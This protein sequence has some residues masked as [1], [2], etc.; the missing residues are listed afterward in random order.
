MKKVLGKKGLCCF[1]AFV[2]CFQMFF[3]NG[4]TSTIA[5]AAQST[6]V[7]QQKQQ[8]V[9]ASSEV[10]S[11]VASQDGRSEDSDG[12]SAASDADSLASSEKRDSSTGVDS[13]ASESADDQEAEEIEPEASGDGSAASE[14]AVDK[15]T[16]KKQPESADVDSDAASKGESDETSKG[17][18]DDTS[19]DETADA[20]EK[21]DGEDDVTV[22][23][24][25]W[26][27]CVDNLTLSTDGLE[28]AESLAAQ[29]GQ[30][31]EQSANGETDAAVVGESAADVK[32]VALPDTLNAQLNIKA[33]LDV[34]AGEGRDGDV[35]SEIVGGDNF[36]IALPDGITANIKSAN[37][38]TT[39]GELRADVYSLD[40]ATGKASKEV[41]G[42]AVVN[43]SSNTI[44]IK[45]NAPARKVSAIQAVIDLDVLV[46]SDLVK[47]KESTV[48]WTIQKGG[49]DVKL[50]VPSKLDVATALGLIDAENAIQI[51]EETSA[52][53]NN[54]DESTG[55]QIGDRKK[56]QSGKTSA[57]QFVTHWADNNAEV[58]P[59]AST[60]QSGNEYRLYY[61]LDGGTTKKALTIDGVNLTDEAKADL[62]IES[63][64]PSTGSLLS[65]SKTA[66][67]DYTVSSTN[68][69]PL[70]I[71]TK[72]L[73]RIDVD[74]ETGKE[75]EVWEDIDSKTV[76]YY[77]KHD[78]DSSTGAAIA[79]SS[80]VYPGTDGK[81]QYIVS[82][83]SSLKT[84]DQ[85]AGKYINE[86]Q[87]EVL[88]LLATQTFTVHYSFGSGVDDTFDFMSFFM[89]K[90][91][92]QT[93]TVHIG[94]FYYNLNGEY[95]TR[96]YNEGY[97]TGSWSDSAPHSTGTIVVTAPEYYPDGTLME[98]SYTQQAEDQDP[99]PDYVDEF[100]IRYDNSAGTNHGSD[101]SAVYDGGTVYLVH[102]GTTK[103]AATKKWADD[104]ASARPETTYSLWRYVDNGSGD[105]GTA[106]PVKAADNSAFIEFTIS[107]AV[108]QAA[109]SDGI[110]LG[111]KLKEQ[112]SATGTTLAKYDP[113]G[114]SY[115]YMLREDAVN[116]YERLYGTTINTDESSAD[117]GKIVKGSDTKPN[118]YGPDTTQGT[119][120]A[121]VAKDTRP[122][123]DR[124]VYNNGTIINRRT[125]TAT[126][127]AEKSWVVGTFQ[128]LLTNV[129]SVFQLQRIAKVHA[130]QN[131]DGTYSP[132]GDIDE[133]TGAAYDWV[134][135]AGGTKE[136]TGW[137]AETLTQEF[138]GGGA[139]YDALGEE[140][141]YR[142][143]ETD[144][145]QGDTSVVTSTGEDGVTAFHLTL[146]DN[147]GS[148]QDVSFNVTSTRDT[149]T[150]E[151]KIKNTYVDVTDA[152]V[153]KY[154][155]ETETDDEGNVTVKKD[156][157]GNIIWTQD[158]KPNGSSHSIKF[159]IVRTGVDGN[160]TYGPYTL[161]GTVD[162]EATK[163]DG[164]DGATVQETTPW[165]FD[166]ENLPM[167]DDNGS[168]YIYMCFETSGA[169][170]WSSS[171]SYTPKQGSE[172]NVTTVYNSPSPGD[173]WSRLS[174]TKTWVDGGNTSSRVPVKVGIYA[175][176]EMYN[177]KYKDWVD[178]G[179]QGDMPSGAVHYNEGD[180]IRTVTL[181]ESNGWYYEGGISI[182]NVS[183]KN[184]DVYIRELSNGL[185]G[186]QQSTIITKT[187]AQEKYDSDPTTYAVYSDL[188]RNWGENANNKYNERMLT[189]AS[190]E[191]EAYCYQVSY[192]FSD[193]LN[194][195][196]VENRR[197]GQT[198]IRVTK[199]WSDQGHDT[200][201]RPT[202]QFKI[203]CTTSA[204]TF[205]AGDDG[206][207]YAQ[208]NGGNKVLL[209][210]EYIA[211]AA[212]VPMTTADATVSEDGR[213]L[214]FSIDTTDEHDT[215]LV[216]SLPK[217][218]GQGFVFGYNVEEEITQ[219]G[220]E[221]Y[222]KQTNLTVKYN[223]TYHFTDS[224]QVEFTNGRTGTKDVVFNT[225]WYDAY[226]SSTLDSR[227]DL[228][229]T[230]YKSVYQYDESGNLV[231]NDDGTP[232][233]TYE[234]VSDYE[235]YKWS[236]LVDST[237]GHDNERATIK[238][239]Q[240]YDSHGK[241]IIYYATCATHTSQTALDNLDYQKQWD[242]TTNQGVSGKDAG[243]DVW[244]THNASDSEVAIAAS[245]ATLSDTATALREDGTF[246]YEIA[247]SI[248][249]SG[250]KV[251]GNFPGE[252]VRADL[253]KISVYVQRRVAN[254]DTAWQN[255][256]FTAADNAQGYTID[257]M[258]SATGTDVA[259]GKTVLA[260]THDLTYI[261]AGKFSFAMK[262][263]GTN[264][265]GSDGTI[266]GET[267][268][269]ELP[270]YDANGNLYEYRTIEVVD[271][272]LSTDSNPVPGGFTLDELNNSTTDIAKGNPDK[273]FVTSSGDGSSYTIN[274]NYGA[275]TGKLTVKK[276]FDG[277]TTGDKFSDLT[278]TLYRYYI[279]SSDGTHS[280]TEKV[281]TKTLEAG[282][283]GEDGTGT[284][285]F[286][287]VEI[288][289]P[290][291]Q[292]WVYYVEETS[293]DGYT[294]QVMLGNASG[295]GDS[296]FADATKTD[297]GYASPD[298]FEK[299]D[300]GAYSKSTRVADD[301]T[302]DFTFK[303]TYV[304]ESIGLT[305]TKVW[306]DNGNVA[307]IRPS[308]ISITVK[309]TYSDGTADQSLTDGKLVLQ[310]TDASAA[311]YLQWTKSD[312]G[313]WTY[314]VSNV[315]KWAT[316]GA[317]WRYTVT[318][319]SSSV[320][321]TEY[322]IASTGGTL[323]ASDGASF[324]NIVNDLKT[325]IQPKKVWAGDDSDWLAQRPTLYYEL[326]ARFTSGDTT[327]AWEEVGNAFSNNT[328]SCPWAENTI[329]VSGTETLT[330][331]ML[332][333]QSDTLSSVGSVAP[334]GKG[335][336]ERTG[337]AWD[338]L[339]TSA[340]VG[341]VVKS[342]EYRVV[343]KYLVY[344]QDSGAPTVV[345]LADPDA[346][347][348]YAETYYPYS[349]SISSSTATGD[350]GQVTITST[351]TNTLDST[352]VSVTKNWDDEDN[353]WASRPGTTTATDEWTLQFAIQRSTDGANWEWV[354]TRG[355]SVTDST[356]L[357]TDGTFNEN[358]RVVELSSADAT[359]SK[360]FESLPA[361]D[362][363]GNS[364]TYRLAE[365][366]TG[367]YAVSTASTTIATA[368]DG[369][370]KLVAVDG[371][372]SVTFNNS[373]STVG[374]EGTKNWNDYSADLVPDFDTKK[375]TLQLQQSTDGT[376][377]TAAKY[378]DGTVPT[379]TWT[380]ISDN[381]WTY[382]YTGLPATD[383]DGN[384]ITYRARE[385]MDAS[386]GYV[387]SSYTE[388]T[389]DN[390]RQAFVGEAITNTATRFSLK[391]IGD[392]T[393]GSDSEELDGVTLKI[394]KTTDGVTK[395]YAVW[396]HDDGAAKSYVNVDGVASDADDDMSN[397]KE[398]TG[399]NAGYI[400]ALAAGT[401]TIT[402]T[403]TPDGHLQAADATVTIG[404]DGVISVSGA[405]LE[406][407]N[408]TAD[409]TDSV[410]RG[411]VEMYKYYM[412]AGVQVQM[413][414]MTFDLYQGTPDGTNVKIAEGI[415]LQNYAKDNNGKWYG[416][417]TGSLGDKLGAAVN[418]LTDAS[419]TSLLGKYYTTTADGLPLGNYFFKET[420]TSPYTVKAET[421][422]AFEITAN[423]DATK[424]PDNIFY[425][426]ANTEFN[427]EAYVAKAN[428]EDGST[429]NNATFKL[430]YIPEGSTS[431]EWTTIGSDFVTGATY[432]IGA[433]MSGSTKVD[434]TAGELR[435]KY[436]KKGQYRLT[437]LSDAGYEV[438]A[439]DS[440]TVATWTISEDDLNKTVDLA[441]GSNLAVPGV[442]WKNAAF[443]DGKL[444]N[445]PKH[446]AVKMTKVSSA[447][448]ATTIS[449][450]TMKLQKK[451]GDTWVD[452]VADSATGSTDLV[453]GKNYLATVDATGA[454]TA[455]T[456]DASTTADSGTISV[457]NLPWG[458]YKFV[459]TKQADGYVGKTGS[460]QAWVESGELA[461]S[462][463]NVETSQTSPVSG[464]NVVNNP[465]N[466][467]IIKANADGTKYL[468]GAKFTV[469]GKFVSGG[470]TKIMTKN[471]TS[472]VNTGEAKP[473]SS[474]DELEGQL[475]VGETYTVTESS[476]PDGY[477]YDSSTSTYRVT[478]TDTGQVVAA[479]GQ[480]AVSGWSLSSGDAS[481]TV[482]TLTR[483]NTPTKIIVFKTDE[484]GD[485]LSGS[486]FTITGE[487]A[488]G[489]KSATIEP[490]GADTSSI[491]EKLIVGN[492]Y[493]IS[494]SKVPAGYTKIADV[495]VKVNDD[496]SLEFVGDHE[497][498]EFVAGENWALTVSDASAKFSLKK[499]DNSTDAK[500][501]A[502]ATF[503]VKGLFVGAD[504][505]VSQTTKEFTTASDKTTL[506]VSSIL[507]EGTAY[508]DGSDTKTA[509]GDYVISEKTSPY[510][511]V[512]TDKT[513]TIHV[514]A[515]GSVSA[516]SSSSDESP[517]SLDAA[518]KLVTLTDEA[519]SF[520]FAKK[521][522]SGET[523]NGAEFAIEGKFADTYGNVGDTQT[524]TNQS[525][526]DLSALKY[527]QGQTYKLTETTAPAG[528][529]LI[530]GTVEF[531]LDQSGKATIPDGSAVAGYKVDSAGVSIT[532]TDGETSITVK[533]T[534]A[535]GAALKGAVFS[536]VPAAGSAFADG[537]TDAISATT[538]DDG[539]ISG[540]DA[541]LVAKNTYYL[542][543][544]TAPAGY[545]Q[546]TGQLKIDVATDG[547]IS[548]EPINVKNGTFSVADSKVEID[549]VDE[550]VTFKLT[551]Y[552]SE[553]YSADGAA[554]ALSSATFEVTPADGST[555]ADGS[556]ES[557][558]FTT[559]D[560]G[561]GGVDEL[562]CKLVVGS[563]YTLQET[564]APVGY[565]LISG[566]MTFKV[567]EDG[568]LSATGT[569]PAAY[570]MS[571]SGEVTVFT[572]DATDDP[573]RIA[574]RKVSAVSTALGLGGATFVLEP[575]EGSTFADGTTT[576]VSAT[577]QGDKGSSSDTDAS[578]GFAEFDK[579]KL[580]ADGKTVYKIS[581]TIAPWGY[582][583]NT[584]V[585]SF[586]MSTDGVISFTDADAA[587]AA[588]YSVTE[589]GMFTVA[590]Q[591]TPIEVTL[592]KTDSAGMLMLANT[593]YDVAP[594]EGTNDDGEANHFADGSTQPI[595]KTT[596]ADGAVSLSG[597][598][599]AGNSY[600]VTE[601][602]PTDG[603]GIITESVTFKVSTDGAIQEVS[604]P[605]AYVVDGA[606][607]TVTGQ[608]A[609]I[610][611][612]FAK[613]S[614]T[615]VL[616]SAMA[617]AQFTIAPVN[618]STFVGNST[619]PIVMT[620]GESGA[621][622]VC[623]KQLV[624]GGTYII[625]E[626][627]A[628]AG[629]TPL[630]DSITV[631][632]SATGQI[633]LSED[634]QAVTGWSL[635]QDGSV[636]VVS[637][638]DGAVS[639][640]LGKFGSDSGTAGEALAGAE[641]TLTG[642]FSKG[643]GAVGHKSVSIKTL[644]NNMLEVDGVECPTIENLVVDETYV[645]TETKAPVGYRL[646][647]TPLHF[648][649]NDSGKVQ[650]T[651]GYELPESYGIVDSS[652]L[653]ASIIT[654]SDKHVEMHL[655]KKSLAN[656]GA[657][658]DPTLAGAAF[659][660][661]A[662]FGVDG[663]A[664]EQTL[665]VKTLEGGKLLSSAS[666]DFS[667][668]KEVDC[669]SDFVSTQGKLEYTI[670]EISAPDGYELNTGQ[671]SFG[672]EDD[673][674]VVCA[675]GD[676]RYASEGQTVTVRDM[677]ITASVFK[678]DTAGTALQGAEFEI[679]A[680]DDAKFLDGT[681]VKKIVS[682]EDGSAAIEGLVQGASYS[683][684]ET[685]APEGYEALSDTVEFTV[686]A[687]GK[688]TFADNVSDK[689]SL[690][691]DRDKISVVNTQVPP[692]PSPSDDEEQSA[693]PL[694]IIDN[695]VQTGDVVP[696]ATVVLSL[697]GSI[698]VL[699]IARRR[700]R[701][702]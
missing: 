218:D 316:D 189:G 239:L 43:S 435:F 444:S 690:N 609:S 438:G 596:G 607:A 54:A 24:K 581:E 258:A 339:P 321:G 7:E 73:K 192:G 134:D 248:N 698:A 542:S 451:S 330:G 256:H 689:F 334:D 662:K 183:Q 655:N 219:T 491:I 454:I 514:N 124:S 264:T 642:N 193:S 648:T 500:A 235:N 656:I 94:D 654:Q 693:S 540:L 652:E 562:T 392:T 639:V 17:G 600:T 404:T 640:G 215:V 554:K 440:A 432:E 675:T 281:A 345:K 533:K 559:G 332:Q 587:A 223:S 511:Y 619:T 280:P 628:P 107:A 599:A 52:L 384:T 543:E 260:A 489:S 62:G 199:A 289:D 19:K 173:E 23:A 195:M 409:V 352:S 450:T 494:E 593:T 472:E 618:G 695:L 34:S 86:Y 513:F 431:T 395:T 650:V 442:T 367:S 645:L 333:N 499:T 1:M 105:Y 178:G 516:K 386:N 564:T 149:Q 5:E 114:Y 152:H 278:Y 64:T 88:S 131:A 379:V 405:T 96:F 646:D 135:V 459:E 621:S 319:D 597:V 63:L 112:L 273:V 26:T 167:Y 613:S 196:Q 247:S 574:V 41:V 658:D 425:R 571:K 29:A 244:D 230:L 182:G 464:D 226:V 205:T 83:K 263:Y 36:E 271:G 99:D 634:S 502:N 225:R 579:A 552:S 176:K 169:S 89:Q 71:T 72:E 677:P 410:F 377:W 453:T 368:L 293:V 601:A 479:E 148:I 398:M 683:L 696:L 309:R 473:V 18:S 641:Y 115:V 251:W 180:L 635:S 393:T 666:A 353:K 692:T 308:D 85:E 557:I 325:K 537:T 272:L 128:D 118:Y 469:T 51:A 430:E 636:Y 274:N 119:I 503:E 285:D 144:V 145:K 302:P 694:S 591:D 198:W 363:S 102:S 129:T 385:V 210:K 644:E 35:E 531:T 452:V 77:I 436:L 383:K 91:N 443:K 553:G 595:S 387:D 548:G 349:P 506:D 70:T 638:V 504:G 577:T 126:V 174:V 327:S 56:V 401:Y 170:G 428:S 372:S 229:L 132:N 419:G 623:S 477:T 651:E 420:G 396:T 471:L 590:V 416:W 455:L 317:A 370:V 21:D 691:V 429:V 220:S 74:E 545:K 277:Y 348:K 355:A 137:T 632:V 470:T 525:I 664:V 340:K 551:K 670:Q 181:S 465:T 84:A 661:T 305:G 61:S 140:F 388:A 627:K 15:A 463:D 160:V 406:S 643:N 156:E 616:P 458:T 154:W 688:L 356:A 448:T 617:G 304:P 422:Y 249:I 38:A 261:S 48:S 685:K 30:I 275:S 407:D 478:M 262:Y 560:N 186:E 221:Y 315:E 624:A 475:I 202:C 528:Y 206:Y 549:A 501:L 346:D 447:S 572:G 203:S 155:A 47:S 27:E 331:H 567:N 33:K 32:D 265:T 342:I 532:A 586:I 415:T 298:T 680:L 150:G 488:D 228:Y 157:N 307:K 663:E 9:K 254:S 12:G 250:Q 67:Y 608:D 350:D 3:T 633:T 207:I 6:S 14:S 397:F 667:D 231:Y 313:N 626:T 312:T 699:G 535:G 44:Q 76:T 111:A 423:S 584:F 492:T 143:I 482:S 266:S 142:Y 121:S 11:S 82:P 92:Y 55:S 555:F 561:V 517:Y 381:Q 403:R 284:V 297:S 237:S 701:K 306:N 288:Y 605:D 456:E 686:G 433:S 209:Y 449:G 412:H 245:T 171:R 188:L 487:M 299:S 201:S 582:E 362:T 606:N 546:I 79:E 335:S 165:N 295:A 495:Q 575:A 116:G 354:T 441:D 347:G 544:T 573:T 391:K 49:E 314:A 191:S 146:T 378:A 224:M 138:E 556:A 521:N 603:Y 522:G 93:F 673:G 389:W 269:V 147:D 402:E 631:N 158:E 594:A 614:T 341:D 338:N 474:D 120:D 359:A 462:R 485:A 166:F 371:A 484:N 53:Q 303:N 622:D 565:T 294:T 538:A 358:L 585:A 541:V 185:A 467:K 213:Y 672:F 323:T 290:N 151:T 369:K 212:D 510:G 240:K 60:L 526:S 108:N 187:E 22:V 175:A 311:N 259:D 520:S 122:S 243:N 373:L 684:K 123:D 162:S 490:K 78:Y 604:G 58:R 598:L 505:A 418:Y 413:P 337:T 270:K 659:K 421:T 461:I 276:I 508:A 568:S 519:I 408:L 90:P 578:T 439:N 318:E 566:S 246:N 141:V 460:S 139:K 208:V 399:D 117:Y 20:D 133:S 681:S 8:L 380:K 351:M 159:T 493:T 301:T 446:G 498:W 417:A 50:T 437:E 497:G 357:N 434:G 127:Q 426:A 653:A 136:I 329:T 125:D 233:C 480:G 31:A 630:A 59:S 103:Y 13:T 507:V 16:E 580:I 570:H 365:R 534:N 576:A 291:G 292:Y 364:Y 390:D 28:F 360:A 66:T 382:S 46:S 374:L 524:L 457:S 611:L 668:A 80:K 322:V 486:E 326:Q 615:E 25:D 400:I 496:G 366:L 42:Y 87:E 328:G 81:A 211:G 547:T 238:N 674:T 529:E 523:L 376:N 113:A 344:G 563:S 592:K 10:N 445:M 279:K 583:L 612:S 518:N 268:A 700:E 177:Q 4:M 320:E 424:Q 476:S 343:E 100:A 40:T 110:D 232:K 68:D 184:G 411:N 625:S 255:P 679:R 375:P 527:A 637:A 69:L 214:I 324:P 550:V 647:S 2:L 536:L 481:S 253:P 682:G 483:N 687:D 300:S 236:T 222:S 361:T 296:S 106:S 190:G 678:T 671:V 164:L 104:D 468:G 39:D 200:D 539:T 287:N 610:E 37:V 588:G 620:I 669:L 252:Y 414:G 97:F 153:H 509:S 515:D 702:N 242:T 589:S 466:L 286:E 241:E 665:Y 101:V 697:V 629:F 95:F 197:L 427:V 168:K 394:R 57:Q 98:Y 602:I 217:Y 130:K 172:S 282:N 283:I 257:D 267:G 512:V 558:E 234:V 310:T 45:F 660:I 65:V 530:Q 649:V 676:E 194:A 336:S 75:T 179:S 163:I 569:C 227:P 109:G 204:V 657:Q 216:G 161:D